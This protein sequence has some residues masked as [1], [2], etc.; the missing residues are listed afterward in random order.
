MA[1]VEGGVGPA[2]LAHPP[3][4]GTGWLSAQGT[5]WAVGF[6]QRGA[7]LQSPLPSPG[8][9]EFHPCDLLGLPCDLLLS[10][11]KDDFICG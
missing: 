9:Q 10:L 7:D 8:L 2:M 3:P 4:P 6:C 11:V 5:S 1:G